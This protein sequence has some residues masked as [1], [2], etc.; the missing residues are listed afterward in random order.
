M[1]PE[2]T[3]GRPSGELELF[4]S[5]KLVHA[6]H[7]NFVAMGVP[8]LI[9]LFHQ[10]IVVRR[11]EHAPSPILPRDVCDHRPVFKRGNPRQ[12]EVHNCVPNRRPPVQAAGK[13]ERFGNRSL[14][15][16]K[17]EAAHRGRAVSKHDAIVHLDAAGLRTVLPVTCELHE[18]GRK[19]S[20]DNPLVHRCV[21]APVVCVEPNECYPARWGQNSRTVGGNVG[22]ERGVRAPE[23]E[24]ELSSPMVVM[25]DAI[26]IRVSER[27]KKAGVSIQLWKIV[28][29]PLRSA[30]SGT[31]C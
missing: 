12:C 30:I 27:N 22:V 7:V 20:P 28:C 9:K 6:D 14:R 21:V 4:H 16:Q 26:W 15:A 13:R 18:Q 23:T 19:D 25:S 24:E 10:P 31:K 11:D 2:L 3:H 29:Q 17:V 1:I 8:Q 5:G